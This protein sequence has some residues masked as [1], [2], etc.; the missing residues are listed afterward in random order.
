VSLLASIEASCTVL[1]RVVSNVLALRTLQRDGALPLQP[2]REFDLSACMARNVALVCAFDGSTLDP[3]RIAWTR[4]DEHADAHA[5]SAAPLSGGDALPERVLGDE[6]A[7]EA[8]LQNVLLC[9]VRLGASAPTRTSVQLRVAAEASP[10]SPPHSPRADVVQLHVTARVAPANEC[11]SDLA[12]ASRGPGA[13]CLVVTA[14]TPGRPLT[15]DEIDALLSPFGMAPPTKGGGT[16]LALYVARGLARGMGGELDMQCGRDDATFITARIPLRAVEPHVLACAY[17]PPVVLSPAGAAHA[18]AEAAA[19][20][21]AVAATEAAASPPPPAA[22]NEVELTARMFEC[23]LTNSDDVFAICRVTYVDAPPPDAP[24][25]QRLSV[26]CAYIS[27]SIERGLAYC[28]ASLVGEQLLRVCMPE[29]RGALADAIDAAMRGDGPDG[30]NLSC[31]HRSRTAAGGSIWCHTCGVCEGELLYLVCRDVRARKSVELAL[32]SFTLA[33]THDVR[34]ACNA[35]LVSTAV[36]ERRDCVAALATPPPSEHAEDGD[37]DDGG[38]GTASSHHAAAG[39]EQH[40]PALD[41]GYLVSC[42]RTAC[43]LVLGIVGNVLSAPQ[44]QAGALTLTT[45]VF[46]PAE[47]LKDVLQACRMGCAAAVQPGGSAILWEQEGDEEGDNDGPEALPPLVEADRNRIAQI[48]QNIITNACKFG[49]GRPVRVRAALLRSEPLPVL[50]VRVSDTGRGMSADQAAACFDAGVAAP[51]AIGGG[52]GLGL[53]L[54]RAFAELMCGSLACIKSVPDSGSTFELRVPV[55]VLGED[56]TAEVMATLAEAR[57]AASVDA[58]AARRRLE[59]AAAAKLLQHEDD[60]V[61]LSPLT[62]TT[63]ACAPAAPTARAR[64]FRVLVADGA[65]VVLSARVDGGS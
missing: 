48:A 13:F 24:A 42:I 25:E 62:P 45:E 40:Q 52:T 64:R 34:E 7:L 55:R 57:E 5:P 20:A 59:A 56:E 50:R 11:G 26:V 12:G 1:L 38:G 2:P 8:C 49:L 29:D 43:G 16:G 31:M 17:A 22:V 27:P 19:A 6:A 28:Q 54:S 32:R 51:H 9:A 14:E 44:V 37:D 10:P 53:Y 47:A 30:H 15:A 61:V 65:R 21:S 4:A 41:A 23:L 39:S 33:T 63:H 60:A 36:L 46:S 58:A 18:A 35:V 3:P